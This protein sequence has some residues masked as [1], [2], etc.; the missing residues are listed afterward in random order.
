MLDYMNE[1]P[2]VPLKS[3]PARW[4]WPDRVGFVD[5]AMVRVWVYQGRAGAT[6]ETIRIGAQVRTTRQAV[7]RFRDKIGLEGLEAIT[8]RGRPTIRGKKSHA[9]RARRDADHVPGADPVSA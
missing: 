7:E 3:I 2:L 1:R 4:L 8:T 5:P 9:E 6:L